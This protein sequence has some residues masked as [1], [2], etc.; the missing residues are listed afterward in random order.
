MQMFTGVRGNCY[1]V[2][3]SSKYFE[4]L[5]EVA[6][7]DTEIRKELAKFPNMLALYE[8]TNNSIEAMYLE[9][10]ENYYLEGFR[11]GAL[12]GLDISSDNKTE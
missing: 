8:K 10:L 12:M 2:P 7:N 1:S 3:C 4:L 9:S 6:K 11:F 5:E